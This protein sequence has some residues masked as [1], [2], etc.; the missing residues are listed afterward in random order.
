M[1]KFVDLKGRGF[2]HVH[3]LTDGQTDRQTKGDADDVVVGDANADADAKA[4]APAVCVVVLPQATRVCQ[5]MH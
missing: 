4:A 5:R 1:K 2:A 3:P